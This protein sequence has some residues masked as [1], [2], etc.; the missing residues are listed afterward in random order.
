MRKHRLRITRKRERNES[1]GKR[2]ERTTK[3]FKQGFNSIKSVPP[4]LVLLAKF[5]R[6][7]CQS[8]R[9]KTEIS[10]RFDRET[11]SMYFILS[12][13]SSSSS[14]IVVA[15]VTNAFRC[16]LFI[17]YEK[18]TRVCIYIDKSVSNFYVI[19][20]LQLVSSLI[21]SCNSVG[22]TIGNSVLLCA[23]IKTNA[24]DRSL[25]TSIRIRNNI[26]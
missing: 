22:G 20:S 24:A 6:I 19:E 3:R 26:A 5:P 21:S 17:T 11:K 8:Y 7:P 4:G 12:P 16:F 13:S 14:F 10:S 2:D 15:I 18:Y 9:V 25:V 23:R 1:N